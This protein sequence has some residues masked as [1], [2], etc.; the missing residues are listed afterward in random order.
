R[1]AISPR[2]YGRLHSSATCVRA[3]AAVIE[4]PS[5]RGR[6]YG[7]SLL[8]EKP[9]K[10]N[11]GTL[12]FCRWAREFER[13]KIPVYGLGP[14]QNQCRSRRCLH[15]SMFPRR[16]KP[17]TVI[18]YPVERSSHWNIISGDN[19][20]RCRDYNTEVHPRAVGRGRS[21]KPTRH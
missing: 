21:K 2:V 17:R 13:D 1:G 15:K 11:D 4:A 3:P 18:W 8:A 12:S 7:R 9:N 10:A 5:K 16:E 6:K 19:F 20:V 14:E